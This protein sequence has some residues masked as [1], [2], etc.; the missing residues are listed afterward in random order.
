MTSSL[1]LRSFEN[2]WNLGTH[3]ST[4]L[5]AFFEVD[6][7]FILSEFK[8]G[9]RLLIDIQSATTIDW[10]LFYHRFHLVQSKIPF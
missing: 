4:I 7:S 3:Q 5:S 8:S 9:I 2:E 10:G 1:A 6:V